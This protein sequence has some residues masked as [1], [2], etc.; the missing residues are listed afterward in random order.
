MK[1]FSYSVEITGDE[2]QTLDDV[3]KELDK[4]FEKQRLKASNTLPMIQVREKQIMLLLSELKKVVPA[5]ELQKIKAKA[6][7][8]N[9]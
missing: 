9:Q 6:K 3:E 4:A 5:V 7:S 8:L 2:N 1:Q